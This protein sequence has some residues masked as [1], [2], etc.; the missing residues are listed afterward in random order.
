M[1]D[2][3]PVYVPAS[4]PSDA[5]GAPP[6]QGTK[7]HAKIRLL[8]AASSLLWEKSFYAITVDDICA[9]AGVKKG[10]FYYFF[11]SKAELA[12]AALLDLWTTLGKPGFDRCFAPAL[13]PLLRFTNFF[14][15]V[16]SLQRERKLRCGQVLGSPFFSLGCELGIQEPEIGKMVRTILA[17]QLRYFETA[18][19][20]ALAEQMIDPCDPHAQALCLR[21]AM[22][23][24]LAEAR[25]DGDVDRLKALTDL[26]RVLLGPR[27]AANPG[28]IKPASFQGDRKIVQ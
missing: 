16:I 6:L 20:D 15:W 26:P 1:L 3:L 24:V 23:G 17:D 21:S 27:N 28:E 2:P 8:R 25:I 7:I 11:P 5:N 10:S 4:P 14:E 12:V 22:E 13:P 18:I 9:R 19:R